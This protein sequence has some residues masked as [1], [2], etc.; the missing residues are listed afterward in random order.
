MKD[1]RLRV[2]DQLVMINRVDLAGL[3]NEQGKRRIE[4]TMHAIGNKASHIE[5]TVVRPSTDEQ[6]SPVSNS[7]AQQHQLVPIS[8]LKTEDGE[9]SLYLD[10]KMLQPNPLP[11]HTRVHGYGD[12]AVVVKSPDRPQKHQSGSLVIE[13]RKASADSPGDYCEILG[14][15]DDDDDERP[16]NQRATTTVMYVVSKAHARLHLSLSRR[17]RA[18]YVE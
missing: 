2:N 15:G 5:L 1:G 11:A 8:P 14:G 9:E 13:T 3:R 10:L 12:Y 17:A 6:H 18:F 16:A 7:A 4:Q